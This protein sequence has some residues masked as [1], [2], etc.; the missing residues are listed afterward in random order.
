[1]KKT[2]LIWLLGAFLA[3]SVACSAHKQAASGT[4]SKAEV[5][6]KSGAKKNE[7]KGHSFE[8]AIK[9]NDVPEEY[10]YVRKDCPKC[11]FVSQALVKHDGTYYDVLTFKSGLKIVKYYFDISGFYPGVFG[12]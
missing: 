2:S 8:T 9:V 5:E 6:N 1:M 4:G 11:R 12:E 7:P 10:A 3:L